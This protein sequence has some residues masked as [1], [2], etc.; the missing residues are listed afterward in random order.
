MT[1]FPVKAISK[2]GIEHKALTVTPLAIAR[3]TQTRLCL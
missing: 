3:R 1:A 2:W